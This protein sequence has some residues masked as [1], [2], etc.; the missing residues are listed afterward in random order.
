MYEIPGYSFSAKT[1]AA[2]T[3][4]YVFVKMTDAGIA[5]ATAVA[6]AVVGV[7]QREGIAGEV[8]PVMHSGISMVVASA[9]I[10]KGAKVIPAADGRAATAAGA[11][12]GIALEAATAAGD[13][14]PVLLVNGSATA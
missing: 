7:V 2:Q 9:A 6:D 12:N 10:A 5:P 13:I 1:V 11:C 3:T 4:K 8:L 14:I